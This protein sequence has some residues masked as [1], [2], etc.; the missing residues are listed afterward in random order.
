[1]PVKKPP[2]SAQHSQEIEAAYKQL[3]RDGLIRF[4]ELGPETGKRWQGAIMRATADLI[5]G[6]DKGTD[7]R[8]PF[9]HALLSIYGTSKTES[10]LSNYVFVMMEVESQ[11]LENI[12]RQQSRHLPH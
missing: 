4:G 7:V 3:T 2:D 1:M 11:W 5:K 10:E 9:V 6:G 12:R 8:V